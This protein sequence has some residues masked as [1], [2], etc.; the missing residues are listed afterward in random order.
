MVG[1]GGALRVALV[2][3]DARLC[4]HARRLVEAAGARV[5]GPSE[6]SVDLL[7]VDAATAD[8]GARPGGRAIRVRLAG[9][10]EAT[11]PPLS[12]IGPDAVVELPTDAESLLRHLSGLA[13]RPRARTVGVVGARGGAGA[14][15]FA[16][17][18]ARTAA[19]A[20]VRTALIDLDDAGGGLDILLDLDAAAGPRWADLRDERAGFP[21]EALGLALPRWRAVSVLSGDL[22]GGAR[23]D[24]PGVPAALRALVSEHDLV[25]LDVPRNGWWGLLAGSTAADRPP[26]SPR[27]A[28]A[29]VVGTRDLRSASGAAVLARTL[30][31]VDLRLVVRGP[32][33]LHPEEI[34]HAAGIPLAATMRTDPGSAAAA[35][36]GETP[37]D[38]R[39]APVARAAR[40]V[41][42]DLAIGRR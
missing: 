8:A 10:S 11:R 26:T 9:T 23:P 41:L 15:T 42:A 34:S 14:S 22:R 13:F 40:R 39:R 3:D 38:R 1:S 33:G 21:A 17:A 35:E 6:N 24:D 4:E 28:D 30:E 29:I 20:G 27:C 5:V 19:R 18:L 7:L 36:R 25:V 2:S 37:G 31:D 16:A 32:G 12:G